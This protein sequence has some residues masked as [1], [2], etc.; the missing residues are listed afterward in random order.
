MECAGP[1]CSNGLLHLPPVSRG[2]SVNPVTLEKKLPGPFAW[3]LV[4][5]AMQLGQMPHLVI[6]SF[7]ID[8]VKERRRTYNP[9]VIRDR[10]DVFISVECHVDED[11]GLTE[12][13]AESTVADTIGAGIDTVSTSLHWPLL[14]LV[15]HLDI[16]A[17][18]QKQINKVMG[19]HRLAL[20]ED[21]A[22]LALYFI[23][24]TIPYSTTSD[25]TIE[26]LLVFI[27]QWSINHVPQK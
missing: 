10:S 19:H 14:L 27:N 5:N 1:T 17:R 9:E 22:N 26:G 18:L 21:K 4:G 3:L 2:R 6:F 8:K 13:H 16:Q 24:M 12:A 23:A 20:M 7:V 15:K 25:V 11:T